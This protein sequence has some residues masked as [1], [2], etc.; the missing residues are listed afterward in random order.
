[1]LD[2]MIT[3]EAAPTGVQL[4]PTNKPAGETL[5]AVTV[6]PFPGGKTRVHWTYQ[7]GGR[8]TLAKGERIVVRVEN[9]EQLPGADVVWL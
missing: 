5:T 9:R 7:D 4:W 2:A 6:E 1:M 3:A 8:S